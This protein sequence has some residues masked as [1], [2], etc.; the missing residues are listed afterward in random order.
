L[1]RCDPD[2]GDDYRCWS[3]PVHVELKS[4]QGV[5]ARSFDTELYIRPDS[6]IWLRHR[7]WQ[8]DDPALRA[9][10]QVPERE[11]L[12]E[13]VYLRVAG[14]RATLQAMYETMVHVVLDAEFVGTGRC[15]LSSLEPYEPLPPL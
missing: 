13:D 5:V 1:A 11:L 10:L 3:I 2:V 4:Q 6:A 9:A 7:L 8:L 14:G 12:A 15:N